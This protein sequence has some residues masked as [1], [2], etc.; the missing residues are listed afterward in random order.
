MNLAYLIYHK[1][2]DALLNCS[3]EQIYRTLTAFNTHKNV[4]KLIRT[5]ELLNEKSVI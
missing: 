2:D 5:K 4:N 3:W 1:G